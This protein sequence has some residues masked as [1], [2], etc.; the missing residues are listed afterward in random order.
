MQFSGSGLENQNL[1]KE[2]VDKMKDKPK[3]QK[4]EKPPKEPNSK[5]TLSASFP[6]L[7]DLVME[8]DQIHYLL[9]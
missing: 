8:N 2:R 1:M 6:G 4:S 7:V 5:V 9:T 3:P